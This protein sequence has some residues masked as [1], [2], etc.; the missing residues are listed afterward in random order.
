MVIRRGLSA[1]PSK[2]GSA[3]RFTIPSRQSKRDVDCG[4]VVK[5]LF[6][7]LAVV[8]Q[9]T[10]STAGAEN[11]TYNL[12]NYPVNQ[13]DTTGCPGTTVTISGTIVT[14]GTLGMLYMN[15]YNTH[16]I[17]G[18]I[19]Y[20]A[21]GGSFT[22][23]PLIDWGGGVLYAT[24]TAITC[25]FG[26]GTVLHYCDDDATRPAS[27]QLMYYRWGVEPD[28]YV[29]EFSNPLNCTTARFYCYSPTAEPGSI[30]ANDPWIIA[31]AAPESGTFVLMFSGL[32][33]VAGAAYVRRQS[34]T[35]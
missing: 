11:I 30:A 33:G 5:H 14:D 29:G 28:F 32:L 16:L 2:I 18:S 22:N 26:S 12:V 20:V 7:M 17:S 23:V 24:P 10:L 27:A 31:T 1:P 15:S 25:P 19:S 21:A 35:A 3:T 6:A 4:R 13:M 9:A 34:A 8:L